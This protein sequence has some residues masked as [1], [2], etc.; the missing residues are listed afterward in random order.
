[1]APGRKDT[2]R[3][4]EGDLPGGRRRGYVV[5]GIPGAEGVVAYVGVTAYPSGRFGIDEITLRTWTEETLS[6]DPWGPEPPSLSAADLRRIPLGR[7]D[8]A[9]NAEVDEINRAVID[10]RVAADPIEVPTGRRR[11]PDS[12]YEEMAAR[13]Q[14]LTFLGEP[15]AKMIA[16]QAGVP[17]TTV[18]R[19]VREARRRG[20]LGPARKGAA[21]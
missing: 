13:Y 18:H 10:R 20:F 4:E 3:V 16:E 11:Y 7:I 12:F 17:V 19:W 14:G 9:I 6:D 15:P 21:G 5:T 1:M 8:A 2:L